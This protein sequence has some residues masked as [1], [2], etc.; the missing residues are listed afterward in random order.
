[1]KTKQQMHRRRASRGNLLVTAATLCG[2]SLFAVGTASEAAASTGSQ[3]P[4]PVSATIGGDSSGSGPN[5]EC[6]WGFPDENASGGGETTQYSNAIGANI[7]TAA[8]TLGYTDYTQPSSTV[9][10]THAPTA[11]SGT[12]GNASTATSPTYNFEYSVDSSDVTLS[13]PPCALATSGEATQPAGSATETSGTLTGVTPGAGPMFATTPN[14]G[15]SPAALRVGLWAA[16]DIENSEA[17]SSQVSWNVFYPDLKEDTAVAGIPVNNSACANYGVSGANVQLTDMFNTAEGYNQVTS[18]AV[19]DP[20]N[21]MTTKCVQG[22]KTLYDN[23]FTI[24]KDDP[25]GTWYVE[26]V[27]TYNGATSTMWYSFTVLPVIYLDLDFSSVTFSCTTVNQPCLLLGNDTWNTGGTSSNPAVTELG[28]EGERIGLNFSALDQTGV[29]GSPAQITWFDG[30]VGYNPSTEAVNEPIFPYGTTYWLPDDGNSAAPGSGIVCP[31][32]AAKLDMS[33]EPSWTGSGS[34]ASGTYSG[35]LTVFA[36][37]DMNSTYGCPTDN[38]A[39]YVVDYM[40]SPQFQNL[41]FSDTAPL[42]RT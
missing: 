17:T 7:N 42:V 33:L 5:I 29:A 2:M 13:T 9:G 41:G 14:M 15:D 26:T 12:P 11:P 4:V 27:A 39:P 16:V 20:T 3:G 30:K 10:N 1:M 24:S 18:A 25:S 21:G 28:N 23:S 6:S 19:G 32:D 34:F 40:G 31:N 8:D 22:T 38:G 37:A 36:E 35:T